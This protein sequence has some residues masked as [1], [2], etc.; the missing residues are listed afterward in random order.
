LEGNCRSRRSGRRDLHYGSPVITAANTVIV[1][2]KTGADSFRIVARKGA[3]G[4]ILWRYPTTYQTPFASFLPGMGPALSGDRLFIPDSGGRVIVRN[5]P[6]LT[7]GAVSELFFYGQNNF[8]ADP[9]VNKQ[10]V[11]INTPL[12]IDSHGNL[13]F[14][15]LAVGPTTIGL[16][17]GIARIAANGKGRPRR[18]FWLETRPSPKS[19]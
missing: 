15:F 7:T 10:N 19:Q 5:S 13:F 3:T 8:Q 9:T 18:L 4:Q 11:Q 2:V 16:Q 14:G 12:T 1:P 6:N 17:S